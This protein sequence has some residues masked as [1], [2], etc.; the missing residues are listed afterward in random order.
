M[1]SPQHHLI[2]PKTNIPRPPLPVHR[3]NS[4]LKL[5]ESSKLPEVKFQELEKEGQKVIIGRL[6]IPT[7][8]GHAF[9]LRRYDTGAVSL[10]TMFRAAFPLATD[11]EEK[12]ETAWV[13][14]NYDVGTQKDAYRVRLAGTWVG[15]D[16]ALSVAEAYSISHIIPLLA[17]AEPE[18]GKQ[19]RRSGKPTTPKQQPA[20]P[21]TTTLP[22]PAPSF[23][24]PNPT[25]RRREA[26]PA[27]VVELKPPPSPPPSASPALR[28]SPRKPSPAVTTASPAKSSVLKSTAA[29]TTTVKVG[30][31]PSKPASKRQ[32]EPL[33]PAA[34]DET[35]GEDEL[36]DIHGPDMNE[37]IAEQKELIER[38]KKERDEAEQERARAIEE[39]DDLKQKELVGKKREREDSEEQQYKFEFKEPENKER[40]IATNRRVTGFYERMPPER[41]SAA[42]GA[43]AF[44]AGLGAMTFL[45]N[46]LGF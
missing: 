13:K 30:K 12:A 27:P 26:S 34:S 43:V 44:A 9:I 5:T 28:R 7:P 33:T 15:V 16:V 29:T 21:V 37:D 10:T 24:S 19:Y 11:E 18:E 25:K 36:P 3:A 32:Q 2:Y 14:A 4:Q 40:A 8:S 39:A 22:T 17:A 45:P 35:V 1:P 46:L 31:P 38:L 23:G 20:P 41:K 6:K 42:W